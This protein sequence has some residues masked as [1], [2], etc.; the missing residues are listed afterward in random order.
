MLLVGGEFGLSWKG[1][2]ERIVLGG[3]SYE[4]TPSVLRQV[5]VNPCNF[6]RSILNSLML[7]DKIIIDI[8]TINNPLS[9]LYSSEPYHRSEAVFK[10]PVDPLHD[11]VMFIGPYP[12][13]ADKPGGSFFIP[14]GLIESFGIGA[15]AICDYF[16]WLGLGLTLRFPEDLD[17][18]RD[19]TV[20]S[21]Y[22][23][24]KETRVRVYDF[25]EPLVNPVAGYACLV[26]MPTLSSRDFETVYE[27]LGEGAVFLEPIPDARMVHVHLVDKPK[28]PL[29]F[30]ERKPLEIHVQSS[31]N[32][33]GVNTHPSIIA[34]IQE[35][36]STCFA[37]VDLDSVFTSIFDCLVGLAILTL[38][39]TLYGLGRYMLVCRERVTNGYTVYGRNIYIVVSTQ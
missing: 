23:G 12:C 32:N 16:S 19:T 4:F 14:E 31:V 30:T 15:E 37:L 3:E 9:G 5:Q 7:T 36:V 33:L 8:P 11:I 28:L 10:C 26:N 29:D 35:R 21:Q 25:P 22:R 17:G 34:V 2:E 38:H 27:G 6:S 18:T 13:V 1:M 20:L 24:D 39:N